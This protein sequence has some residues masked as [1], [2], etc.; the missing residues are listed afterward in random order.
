[1]RVAFRL[2]KNFLSLL[3]MERTLDTATDMS[4][5]L[6]ESA[7][8][9]LRCLLY[10][11]IFQFP[12][13]AKE[14]FENCAQKQC[15]EIQI[16]TALKDLLALGCIY[17]F[18]GYYLLKNDASLV[19]RR[20]EGTAKAIRYKKIALRFSAWIA[21][22]PFVEAVLIS[23]S[24][25]KDFV[26]EKGDIDYFIITR[27]GRLWLCRTMLTAFKKIFLLNSRKYFCI[28]YFLDSAHLEIS[29]K[30]IFTATELVYAK[31]TYNPEMYQQFR[32]ANT[33]GEAFYPHMP[34]P[35]LSST[36]PKRT[37]MI[38]SSL[39]W[40]L[41][42]WL[43]EQLDRLGFYITLQFLKHKYSKI[44]ARSFEV[45]FRSRE[46]VSKNHPQGF[47]F[48]VMDAMKERKLDFVQ[49]FNIHL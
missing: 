30:N 29:D 31:P 3:G 48:K 12:L 49:R 16:N 47:Q 7:K 6:D 9:A 23:G 36:L 1:M 25:S 24:L 13:S 44:D 21:R 8:S 35:D 15:S 45:N 34:E 38:K 10:F 43:G 33:W 32:D 42:G 14:I 5:I 11:D 46:Y 17:Q 26:D 27:P 41:S 18:E 22:F 40:M 2:L 20:K 37:S 4:I 39:E 28:N 19:K